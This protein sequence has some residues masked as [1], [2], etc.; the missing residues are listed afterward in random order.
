MSDE[1]KR[2]LWLKCYAQTSDSP[3]YDRIS[4]ANQIYKACL[5]ITLEQTAGGQ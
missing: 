2:E 1:Q 5:E 4:R 3:Y